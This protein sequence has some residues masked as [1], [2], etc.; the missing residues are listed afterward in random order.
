M[1]GLISKGNTYSS[2]RSLYFDVTCIMQKIHN[3]GYC[4]QE[5]LGWEGAN[6]EMD[7]T[8]WRRQREERKSICPVQGLELF[9]RARTISRIYCRFRIMEM[10]CIVA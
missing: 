3:R 8:K 6:C 10:P 1:C 9:D 7:F 4:F 5:R 2:G